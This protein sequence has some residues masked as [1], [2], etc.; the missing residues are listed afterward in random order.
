MAASDGMKGM[1]QRHH[2]YRM[3]LVSYKYLQKFRRHY[4]QKIHS[5]LEDDTAENVW[6][7]I[8]G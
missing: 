2:A 1:E 7:C 8:W 6:R 3:F 5:S 4:V